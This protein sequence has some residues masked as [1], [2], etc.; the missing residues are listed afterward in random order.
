MSSTELLR[1]HREGS[2]APGAPDRHID[3]GCYVVDALDFDAHQAFEDHLDDCENCRREVLEFLETSAE[4]ARLATMGPP[5]AVRDRT[6]EHIRSVR[7]LPP[8]LE[9]SSE[10]PRSYS[11]EAAAP[12]HRSTDARGRTAGSRRRRLLGLAAAAAAVVLLGGAGVI[13]SSQPQ[14]DIAARTAEQREIDLREIDLLSAPDARIVRWRGDEGRFS[15]VVSRQRDEALLIP[16]ELRP[17]GA[18]RTYQVWILRGGRAEP[19]VTTTL[20]AQGRWLRGTLAKAS[21]VA[22]TI[23]PSGGSV[24]PSSPIVAQ[25]SF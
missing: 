20:P 22:V 1:D 10:P 7:P 14:H 12:L 6:L 8:L 2:S 25:L 16:S 5:P 18:G 3:V 4:L 15:L 13:A 9:R 17:P 24:R 19:D 11:T 23:E 21:G